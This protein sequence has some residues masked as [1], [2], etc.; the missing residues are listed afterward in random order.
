[1]VVIT[2]LQFP[3]NYWVRKFISGEHSKIL[4]PLLSIQPVG[5]QSPI[6]LPQQLGIS[7]SYDFVAKE[8]VIH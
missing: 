7:Q 1:M 4:P 5:W 8:T 2:K 3:L 6:P